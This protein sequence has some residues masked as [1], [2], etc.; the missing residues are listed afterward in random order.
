MFVFC[1]EGCHGT[2]K[3][4]L[5]TKLLEKGY[6][7]IGEAFIHVEN[8]GLNPQSVTMEMKWTMDWFTKIIKISQ[9]DPNGIYITDRSPLSSKFYSQSHGDMISI[10]TKEMIEEISILG[11]KIVT[12]CL[13]V[14]KIVLWDRIR[15]RLEKEPY[16]IKY[17]ENNKEWMIKVL[18]M[19]NF[20]Q[21]DEK[22]DNSFIL[23][24]ELVKKTEQIIE[25]HISLHTF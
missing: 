10:L 17:N 5:C 22:L 13:D 4:E 12:I 1:I 3:T 18:S 2:G 14:D 20:E 21:W 16:R 9:S 11:I 15:Y 23:I 7:V 6:N 25:K 24:G 8:T 19:Y